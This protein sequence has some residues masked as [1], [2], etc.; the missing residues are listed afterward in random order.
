MRVSLSYDLLRV[1]S[2][3]KI[4]ISADS[5]VTHSPKTTNPQSKP[6]HK[7]NPRN[8]QRYAAPLFPLSIHSPHRVSSTPQSNT[9]PRVYG[10]IFSSSTSFYYTVYSYF[11]LS[12]LFFQDLC[13]FCVKGSGKLQG[14]SGRHVT[15][16]RDQ[17]KKV[18]LS[19]IYIIIV[20][21]L[22]KHII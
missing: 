9:T 19:C 11:I 2:C 3:Q 7:I 15:H 17:F 1:S 18:R 21:T 13:P 4:C 8:Y 22:L 6:Q 12:V 14:H 20:T 16:T 5:N 10:K